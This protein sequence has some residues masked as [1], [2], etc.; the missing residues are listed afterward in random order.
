MPSV[1]HSYLTDRHKGT[2]GFQQKNRGIL[3]AD[4]VSLPQ[5]GRRGSQGRPGNLETCSSM[6][7][8]QQ[9]SIVGVRRALQ[10]QLRLLVRGGLRHWQGLGAGELLVPPWDR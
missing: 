7:T 2:Q 8:G 1:L 4:R 5:A 9:P 6:Q 3:E 10:G